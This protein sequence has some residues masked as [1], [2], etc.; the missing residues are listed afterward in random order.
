MASCCDLVLAN[1]LLLIDCCF[2]LLCAPFSSI[3]RLGVT[4]MDCGQM[5]VLRGRLEGGV[6]SL[7]KGPL[8]QNSIAASW[9]IL[10]SD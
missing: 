9:M 1:D 6:M 8:V 3:A 5:E 4:G 2:F 10:A 7:F